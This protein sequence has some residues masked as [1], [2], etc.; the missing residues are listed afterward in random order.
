MD[1]HNFLKMEESRNSLQPNESVVLFTQN[2][3]DV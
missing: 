3:E 1:S 2:Q